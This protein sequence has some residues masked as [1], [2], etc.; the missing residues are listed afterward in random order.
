MITFMMSVHHGTHAIY[1]S[2][3]P[4]KRLSHDQ[5][6]DKV[7]ETLWGLNVGQTDEKVTFPFF[8][9]MIQNKKVQP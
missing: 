4:H 3:L 2:K 8:S 7:Q 1:Q 9:N 5:N 6:W